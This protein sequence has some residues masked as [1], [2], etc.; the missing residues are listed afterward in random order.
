MCTHILPPTKW[1]HVKKFILEKILSE[2]CSLECWYGNKK[3]GKTRNI[4][5]QNGYLNSTTGIPLYFMQALKMTVTK[6]CNNIE[7]SGLKCLVLKTNKKNCLLKA[8]H[9]IKIYFFIDNNEKNQIFR[10]LVLVYGMSRNSYK[11]GHFYQ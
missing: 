11:I 2:T 9:P 6:P 10:Y 4:Q 7:I 5:Q 1:V 3:W 8:L